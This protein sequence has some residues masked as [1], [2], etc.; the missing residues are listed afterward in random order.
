MQA[1][2]VKKVLRTFDSGLISE[3]LEV[4]RTK[5]GEEKDHIRRCYCIGA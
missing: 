5:N 1:G 2:D 4:E 3:N